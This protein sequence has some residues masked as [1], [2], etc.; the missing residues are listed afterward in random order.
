MCEAGLIPVEYRSSL[1]A[2]LQ[3][4][5]NMRLPDNIPAKITA[6]SEAPLRLK[7]RSKKDEIVGDKLLPPRETAWLTLCK[8][9]LETV[10][11]EPTAIYP[12]LDPWEWTVEGVNFCTNLMFCDGKNDVQDNINTAAKHLYNSFGS[13]DITCFTDG[14]VQEGTNNG[15]GAATITIPE[16]DERVVFCAP[17]LEL[18]TFGSPCFSLHSLT[19]FWDI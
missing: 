9:H 16:M 8:N 4:E 3:Y 15:G 6:R 11:R 17:P 5:K 18:T 10:P 12:N 14:S 13:L 19:C 2:A 1:N 7:K